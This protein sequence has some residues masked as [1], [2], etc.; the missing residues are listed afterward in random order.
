MEEYLNKFS[1]WMTREKGLAENTCYHYLQ[2]LKAFC[3]YL[4]ERFAIKDITGFKE[5]NH[6]MIRGFLGEQSQSRNCSARTVCRRLSAIRTF[7]HFLQKK[8]DWQ[9]DPSRILES[10]KSK[11]TLPY[12]LSEDE[13]LMLLNSPKGDDWQSLR[14]RTIIEFLYGSGLRVSELVKLTRDSINTTEGLIRVQGK[15]KKIRL[16]PL[17]EFSCA[18]LF[19][20][21]EKIPQKFQNHSSIF[22]NRF[23]DELSTRGVQRIIDKYCL[24]C[25]LPAKITPHSLRHSFA[26][27]MLNNGADLRFLQKVLGHT[28]ILTTEIYTHV[29]RA[30]LL[31]IYNN[32]HPMARNSIK[33]KQ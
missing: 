5:V 8:H 3:N 22:L 26:T 1:L 16:V 32:T 19:D 21:I 28:N 10:P 11:K 24:I 6:R 12:C 23:G 9:T 31:N 18:C 17:G 29:S 15:G 7:Y 13:V 4:F 2:D 27:H 30:Q 14:D 20:Y 25:G 33:V